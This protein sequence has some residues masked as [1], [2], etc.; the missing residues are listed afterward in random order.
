MPG[1]RMTTLAFR[2]CKP[3]ELIGPLNEIEQKNAPETL[4]AAGDLN[5]FSSGSRVSIVGA[6]KASSKGVRRTQKLVK[7]LIEKGCHVVSGLAEGI[8]TAAHTAS[9]ES[10]GRTIA[11][12]GTPL[13]RTYPKKNTELQRQIIRE[14]LAVSQFPLGHPISRKNFIMRNRTMALI[15]DATIIVE[16]RDRSGSLHQGWEAIRL[17]RPLFIMKSIVEENNLEWPEAM[18]PYGAEILSDEVLDFV[19]DILPAGER[20]SKRIAL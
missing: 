12:L 18:I 5:L 16:A 7:A 3:E 4:Y 20:N 9:I 17:G 2:E 6:R 8:D 10:G 19:I 13:D 1:E 14:H 15:S 11:V